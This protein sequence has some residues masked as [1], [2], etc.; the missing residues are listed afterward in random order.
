MEEKQQEQWAMEQQPQDPVHFAKLAK[1][2]T[3][4]E[5]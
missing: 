5:I 2:F 3:H 4:S 1:F